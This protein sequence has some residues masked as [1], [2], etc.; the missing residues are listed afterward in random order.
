MQLQNRST[1]LFTMGISQLSA[2]VYMLSGTS[3]SDGVGETVR[4]VVGECVISVVGVTELLAAVRDVLFG[5]G[6]AKSEEELSSGGSSEVGDVVEESFFP[7][8]TSCIIESAAA[9]PIDGSGMLSPF[10]SVP[11][12]KKTPV[13]SKRND[14]NNSKDLKANDDGH[15]AVIALSRFILF[16]L[17]LS[18]SVGAEFTRTHTHTHTRNQSTK[19][20]AE[21]KKKFKEEKKRRERERADNNSKCLHIEKGNVDIPHHHRDT[22]THTQTLSEKKQ[23]VPTEANAKQKQKIK[24]KKRPH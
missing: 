6:V 12:V 22:H 5:G 19:L 18:Y 24:N 4:E 1:H 14:D 8:E 10:S 2:R 16:S 9:F 13:S 17:S 7:T 20:A 21:K 23:R 15:C 3:S 11:S